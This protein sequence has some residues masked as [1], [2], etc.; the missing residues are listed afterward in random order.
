MHDVKI[1]CILLAVAIIFCAVGAGVGAQYVKSREARAVVEKETKTTTEGSTLEIVYISI[2][3]EV[4]DQWLYFANNGRIVGKTEIEGT[5]TVTLDFNNQSKNIE[6]YGTFTI[7]NQELFYAANKGDKI[8][9]LFD[10][11]EAIRSYAVL[12]EYEEN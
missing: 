6:S 2:D 7:S 12:N 11:D 10:K 3:G 5:K 8:I 9:I 4:I 1:L